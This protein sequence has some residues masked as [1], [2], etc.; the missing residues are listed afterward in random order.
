MRWRCLAILLL[1]ALFLTVVP[2]GCKPLQLNRLSQRIAASNYRDW[3]P[4]FAKLPYAIGLPGGKVN[5]RNVR[6]NLYLSENDFVPRYYDRTFRIDDIRNVD[7]IVVP[8]QGNEYMA[9]TMLS[10][11]LADGSYIGVSAEIRTEKGEE[12]SPILG[13]TRQYEITYVVADERDIVRLRTRHRDADVYV[14]RTVA[15]PEQSQALFL[16]VMERVNQLARQ[17]EF[18]HTLANNCTTNILDH[19]N[20]IKQQKLSYN[21]R[22]LLPG[23][24]AE[25]AYEEGLLDNSVPFEQL[26]QRAWINDLADQHFEDP[27]FS[28]LI[29][30]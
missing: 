9:H 16:D 5:V 14:Y 3:S 11:G 1:A 28:N 27:Q 21:W 18:Y 19:V 7:F 26:K 6:N 25:Y 23:Y 12:Y 8:F 30:R 22:I 2:G 10:F 13:F 20:R 24:S 29:R 4:Q 15:T 17:P